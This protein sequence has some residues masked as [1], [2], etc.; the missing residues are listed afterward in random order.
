[1]WERLIRYAGI[2][3]TK[4][5]TRVNWKQ[6]YIFRLSSAEIYRTDV[7]CFEMCSDFIATLSRCLMM[8]RSISTTISTSIN[9]KMTLHYWI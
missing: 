8:I 3:Q 9:G 1:M 4:K 7:H 2:Y 5:K 6:K